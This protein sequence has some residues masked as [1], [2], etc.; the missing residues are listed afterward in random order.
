MK[1]LQTLMAACLIYIT[2]VLYAQEPDTLQSENKEVVVEKEVEVEIK[3][4][5]EVY[6]A[7]KAPQK[8]I[9]VEENGDTTYIKLGKRDITIVDEGDDTTIKVYDDDVEKETKS[10]VFV[11]ERSDF[12]GHWAGLE[13]GVN[14]F[15]DSDYSMNRTAE[16][17]F[18]NMRTS[19]SWNINLNFLQYSLGLIKDRVGLVTG[20]GIEFSNYHFTNNNSIVVDEQ[21]GQIAPND[22]Y[23]VQNIEP[24]KNKFMTTYLTV[25]LLVEAQVLNGSRS[26][27]IHISAGVIGGLKIGSSTKVVYREDGSKLKDKERDDYNLNALRYGLTARIGYE[28]LN[29]YANYYPTPLFE[30]GKGPELYP[31]ALGIVLAF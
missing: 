26:D 8:N 6:K 15:L 14:D 21:S 20:M 10:V 19:R 18:M 16:N 13:L 24:D 17:E 23:D 11:P 31:F 27:R 7:R 25:P 4:E 22:Y 29:L 1:T 5:T 9:A 30:D 28:F 2:P 3:E 12:K